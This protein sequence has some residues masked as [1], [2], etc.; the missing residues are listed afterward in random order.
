MREN[1][2]RRSVTFTGATAIATLMLGLV[3]TT[4]PADARTDT[5]ASPDASAR[6]EVSAQRAPAA[7][8]GSRVSARWSGAVHTASKERVNAAYRSAYA[9]KLSLPISWLGGSLLSCLPGLTGSGSNNATR[10]ALNFVRS[11]AGLAPVRFS[12]K[13]NASAQR[14]ALIMAANG[15]LDHHPGKSWKCWTS[16]GAISAGR[17]NLALSYPSIQSGQIIDMYMD[18]HGDTNKAVGHRR[19][20][21]NPFSTVMGSGSTRTANALTVIGPTSASQPNPRWVGWPT[22]GYFP[23]TIEPGGRWSLSS[24]L[25]SISFGRAKVAVFKGSK[26]IAVHKFPVENGYG[27]PTIAWQMPGSFDTTAS[28]RVV[29]TGIHKA[30][31]K[32]PL[33][34]SYTVRLFTPAP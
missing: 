26:K 4:N 10:S 15:A 33:R 34:R 19:W 2:G 22:A 24:G 16:T 21:L 13:L 5:P 32:A 20:I 8:A 6:T 9:P 17:S 7:R 23:N 25:K 28:Y 30:G 11:M 14:A 12:S 27:Q 3:V 29:V 31:R 18:D 1:T